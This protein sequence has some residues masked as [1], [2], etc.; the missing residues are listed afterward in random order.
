MWGGVGVFGVGHVVGVV[1]SP[2]R[3]LRRCEREREKGRQGRW[4]R[5]PCQR[6]PGRVARA[7]RG[8]PLSSPPPSQT[9]PRTRRPPPRPSSPHLATE[10]A[11]GPQPSPLPRLPPSALAPSQT[12]PSARAARSRAHPGRAPRP[13]R[14]GGGPCRQ[15]QSL[16]GLERLVVAVVRR[17]GRA[18]VRGGWCA[19]SGRW[20]PV[21]GVMVRVEWALNRGGRW[22]WVVR[23]LAARAGPSAGVE[24]P[25][26]RCQVLE[27]EAMN[28]RRRTMRQTRTWHC[29]RNDRLAS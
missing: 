9:R 27:S 22:C 14:P 8:P 12:R 17:G 25:E 29:Q 20:A 6:R 21:G 24:W 13:R 19:L 26:R 2:T 1:S 11:G 10:A 3:P 4:R 15:R 5:R 23:W 28:A 16:Q 18:V 7:A